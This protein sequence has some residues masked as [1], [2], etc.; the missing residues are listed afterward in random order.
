MSVSQTRN[1][2]D[3][4]QA[5]YDW[6]PEWF[7]ITLA[8]K[9]ENERWFALVEEFDIIGMGGTEAE[10]KDD[11]LALLAAYL[12]SHYAQGHDFFDALRPIP[13]RLKVAIRRD[14]LMG[15]IVSR[16][17]RRPAGRETKLLVPHAALN[18]ATAAC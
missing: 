14:I 17:A 15:G 13:L 5:F 3:A 1:P 12:T 11:M 10:A 6:L 7:E 4:A 18:G 2:E 9:F 16:I 8:T